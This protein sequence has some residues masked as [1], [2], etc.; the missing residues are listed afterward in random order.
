MGIAK[1]HQLQQKLQQQTTDLPFSHVLNFTTFSGQDDLIENSHTP[2]I[3][4]INLTKVNG[5][6]EI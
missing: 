1:T 5:E 2:C 6:L 3:Y 4:F